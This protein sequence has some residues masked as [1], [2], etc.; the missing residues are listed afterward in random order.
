[1]GSEREPNS[2]ADARTRV[3]KAASL[4]LI[5]GL[6]PVTMSRIELRNW[7]HC[8]CCLP[9]RHQGVSERT[10]YRDYQRAAGKQPKPKAPAKNKVYAQLISAWQRQTEKHV[11]YSAFWGVMSNTSGASDSDS[12][13]VSL[14]SKWP[15][16]ACAGRPKPRSSKLFAP[17]RRAASLSALWHRSM[18]C[19]TAIVAY[20]RH[21]A[22]MSAIAVRRTSRRSSGV[23]SSLHR[24][25]GGWHKCAPCGHA[26]RMDHWVAGAWQA[27]P[28]SRA[29][30][31]RQNCFGG[32]CSW[33]HS[34]PAAASDR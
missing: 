13:V 8:Y 31:V 34:P 6:L 24:T 7:F 18:S 17:A 25:K 10:V 9:A 27:H 4:F 15:S 2:K 26:I 22:L 30:C 20:D 5:L 23:S 29:K 3:R 32:L 16:I 1:M 14:L 33:L 19:C 12:Q 21:S 28:R 11:S